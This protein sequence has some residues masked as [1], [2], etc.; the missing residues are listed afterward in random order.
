VCAGRS[1]GGTG[2]AGPGG[3][4]RRGGRVDALLRAVD[5]QRDHLVARQRQRAH[6]GSRVPAGGVHGQLCEQRAGR[7][8]AG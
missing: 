1:A 7:F 5:A 4:A 3:P 8:R 2:R 6:H